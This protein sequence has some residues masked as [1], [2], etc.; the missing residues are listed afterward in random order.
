MGL[1][2]RNPL[3]WI[4]REGVKMYTE[5]HSCAVS[6]ETL[7]SLGTAFT[8]LSA[9]HQDRSTGERAIELPAIQLVKGR[10][11]RRILNNGRKMT[12]L[13]VIMR[14]KSRDCYVKGKE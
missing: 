1:E 2:K 12:G 3:L 5:V 9:V 8:Q 11:D 14:Y 13:E 10:G 7:S 6:L 4:E